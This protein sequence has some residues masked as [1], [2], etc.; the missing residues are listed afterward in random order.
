MQLQGI[1]R[2]ADPESRASA[3][4]GNAARTDSANE[5][6]HGTL[7]SSSTGLPS[8]RAVPASAFMC[9]SASEERSHPLMAVGRQDSA[10]E[11]L[12]GMRSTG[13][14]Q[15]N[16]RGVSPTA[17]GAGFVR[18]SAS[19]EPSGLSGPGAGSRGPV[20]RAAGSRQGS[21]GAGALEQLA[22]V[23]RRDSASEQ[24]AASSS[25]AGP[26]QSAEVRGLRM[27]PALTMSV[28]LLLLEAQVK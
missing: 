1:S 22:D 2:L 19:E 14:Q 18:D 9:D 4:G 10:E 16:A 7:P 8:S 13:S 17:R 20:L 12:P 26:S 6:G 11:E 25:V 24:P 28:T 5:A 23:G 3:P 21:A 27:T 15:G